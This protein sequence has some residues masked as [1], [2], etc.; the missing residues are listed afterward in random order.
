MQL[1][2]LGT[3]KL[4]CSSVA[5]LCA[6]PVWANLILNGS[7]EAPAVT[8]GGFENFGG[9]A[10]AITGWTVVGVDS[11][12]VSGTFTQSGIVFQAKEGIQWA[13]LAGVTSNSMA[14]GLKQDV[15]TTVG[16]LYEL[17]FNV[18]S[19][20]DGVFF[21]ATT[22]DSSINGGERTHTPT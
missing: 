20:T 1:G 4:A 18:G 13:D 17:T 22:V 12:I 6:T 3:L 10:S 15:A 21:F 8:I 5:M 2:I 16:Q 19:A 11:A 14:S 9:G 7:F